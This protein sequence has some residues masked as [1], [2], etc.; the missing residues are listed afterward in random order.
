MSKTISFVGNILRLGWE[1]YSRIQ[2]KLWKNSNTTL[3]IP[4]KSSSNWISDTSQAL[5]RTKWIFRQIS[6]CIFGPNPFVLTYPR[7]ISTSPFAN[8]TNTAL[9]PN[10]KRTQHTL[11]FCL[12]ESWW[13]WWWTHRAFQFAGRTGFH[14]QQK[15]SYNSQYALRKKCT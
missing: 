2:M 10:W 6:Y 7:I 9:P 5:I 1:I 13:W 8:Q 11:L 14:T 3:F 15:P 4:F 12:A